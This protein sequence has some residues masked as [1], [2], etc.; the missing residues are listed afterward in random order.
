[1]AD[2][3]TR[4]IWTNSNRGEVFIKKFDYQGKEVTESI[5]H[6]GK[7]ALTF[8][9]RKMNQ[10]YAYSKA[11][12]LFTNG[13]LTPVKLF[14]DV[15]DYEELAA[16]PSLISDSDMQDLFKLTA[17][18]F[19]K[20]LK[21]IDNVRVL[22]KIAELSDNEDLNASVPQQKAIEAR[23]DELNPTRHE[24]PSFGDYTDGNPIPEIRLS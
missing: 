23:L 2:P 21:E 6:K 24:L 10:D 11:Q 9:E 3:E 7:V 18:Q 22:E 8:K 20:K 16:N 5:P 12:D 4:E 1:M 15:P 17:P 19:K 13:T 14:D